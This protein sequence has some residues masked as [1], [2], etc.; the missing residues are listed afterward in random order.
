MKYYV[1][2]DYIFNLTLTVF[3]R[4]YPEIQRK[5]DGIYLVLWM[6]R[7]KIYRLR[8]ILRIFS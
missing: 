3:E 4:S 8:L 2:L 5:I 1:N 7:N 6:K